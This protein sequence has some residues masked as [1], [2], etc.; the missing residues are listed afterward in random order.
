M[1]AEWRI[2][3][4][5]LGG[6]APGA[7]L[8]GQWRE[9]LAA[10]P[11]NPEQSLY[12]TPEWVRY[13]RL[14]EPGSPVLLAQARDGRGELAGLAPLRLAQ[15]RL[16]Y[17]LG[18]RCLAVD[19]IPCL[20][21]MGG[22]P[23]WPAEPAAFEQLLRR[24][25]AQMD[26]RA[27]ALYLSSVRV[28]GL[29]WHY[30][31][32]RSLRQLGYALYVPDG[33]RL[34]RSIAIPDDLAAYL[35][36]FSAKTRNTLRRKL[37]RAEERGLRVWRAERAEQVPQWLRDA[38]RVHRQSWQRREL[39]TS[40]RDE[41]DQRRQ[42]E[43][44]A[45]AGLLRCYLLYAGE[46]ACAF[47]LGRQHGDVFHY[48]GVGYDPAMAGYSPSVVLLLHIIQDLS[49]HRPARLMDLGLGDQEYK[50]HFGNRNYRD[51]PVLLLRRSLHNRCRSSLHGGFR[52][53]VR[54]AKR[55]RA[56]DTL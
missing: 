6:S 43:L 28:G 29:F 38:S 31:Q 16:R 32:E 55:W 42:L 33:E 23:L 49:R 27:E 3:L 51:A 13:F 14:A 2:E 52:R 35:T 37:R 50:R 39:G 30:L 44:L 20:A 9:L 34:R 8:L 53:M 21:L 36:Q 22:E 40:I 41:P 25:R 18:T 5:P 19:S 45:E 1:G 48:A 15:Y 24:L 26:G 10:S 4:Q 54:C 46:H 17:E 7:N 12:R 56:L 11:H 47:V